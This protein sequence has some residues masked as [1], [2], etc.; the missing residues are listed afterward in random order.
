MIPAEQYEIFS[1]FENQLQ[2]YRHILRHTANPE[3]YAFPEKDMVIVDTDEEFF[4]EYGSWPL[5]RKHI[6]EIVTNLQE[7]GAKVVALDMLMDFPNG[8]GEDPILAEALGEKPNTMV[9]GQLNLVDEEI[10]GVTTATPV[11]QEATVAGYT[12]HTLIG[13]RLSRLRFYD[14]AVNEFKMWPW[15]VQALAMYWN[16]EPRLENNIL[17][18][19]DKEIP[20][21]HNGDLWLDYP[22]HKPGVTF[23]HEYAG[24]TAAMVLNLYEGEIYGLEDLDE[25]EWN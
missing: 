20:L 13:N 11:L 14:Q 4:S 8:Y 1:G 22:L 21:D 6:A 25:D 16:V 7:L 24:I 19:G 9:V 10:R 2:G 5:Q 18:I 23:L 12:N 15:A 3:A 17:Y